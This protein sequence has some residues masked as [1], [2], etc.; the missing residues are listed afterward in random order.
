LRA[1]LLDAAPGAVVDLRPV[2]AEAPG[3]AVAAAA[4]LA[5]LALIA[6]WRL[7]RTVRQV[8]GAET[9]TLQLLHRF[10][11]SRARIEA[12]VARPIRRRGGR[13]AVAGALLGAAS[14]LAAVSLVAPELAGASSG[15]A[16][17]PVA[18]A[19]VASALAAAGCRR[20]VAAATGQHLAAI[21][22]A[23]A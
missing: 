14:G 22:R 15:V 21:A 11:A 13:G 8:L 3:R 18:S 5:T 6:R 17:V 7:R 10:G 20:V 23:A 1:R 9:A 19:L 12:E 4:A 2:P 16:A